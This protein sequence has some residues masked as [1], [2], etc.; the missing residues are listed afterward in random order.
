MATKGEQDAA[1]LEV[2]AVYPDLCLTNY[3]SDG[4]VLWESKDPFAKVLGRGKTR[5]LAV[6]DAHSRL[7]LS[8]PGD[9]PVKPVEAPQEITDTQ[10]FSIMDSECEPSPQAEAPIIMEDMHIYL[11]GIMGV[12]VHCGFER[13]NKRHQVASQPS[14]LARTFEGFTQLLKEI[15]GDHDRISHYDRCACWI[16][17]RIDD[18]LSRQGSQPVIEPLVSNVMINY[19][20]N[21]FDVCSGADDARMVSKCMRELQQH[22]KAQQER[23]GGRE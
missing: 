18:L 3:G 6:A 8:H 14:E 17:V 7:A 23:I 5:Q 16:C 21:V 4:W 1:I 15:K 2:K 9:E 20:L 12:C 22:R 13:A 11:P 10:A 19:M